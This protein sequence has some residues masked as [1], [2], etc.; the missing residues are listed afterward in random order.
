MACDDTAS[1]AV[2]TYWIGLVL[3]L[4]PQTIAHHV[5]CSAGVRAVARQEGALLELGEPKVAHLRPT[6]MYRRTMHTEQGA[7]LVR[8]GLPS[9]A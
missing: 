3:S 5:H 2:Y 7:V 1:A 6:H 4:H 9:Q 8:G